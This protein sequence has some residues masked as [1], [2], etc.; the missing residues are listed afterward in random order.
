[1]KTSQ[2]LFNFQ[3]RGH[4][5]YTCF[6]FAAAGLNNTA[7]RLRPR[8]TGAANQTMFV[9]NTAPEQGKPQ[10]RIK[11]QDLVAFSSKGGLFTDTLAKSLIV[12][13]YAEWDELYR[14]SIAKEIGV[15]ASAVC[16]DL[17]GDI[18]HVRHW[19]V[20]NKSIVGTKALK[21]LAWQVSTGSPLVISDE[22]MVQFMDQLNEMQVYL[23]GAQQGAQAA[24]PA[25]SAGT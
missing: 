8:L 12:L 16:A 23:D 21:V 10:A 7:E 9:G 4:E 15:Q 5:L 17:M 2:A 6:V 22:F 13:L 3:A 1:M 24:G 19:I 18:R 14:H 25:S 11:M 20:H